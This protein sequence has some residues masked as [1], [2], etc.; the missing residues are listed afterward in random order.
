MQAS[1]SIYKGALSCVGSN[2]AKKGVL[3]RNRT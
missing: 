1:L 2:W 3:R